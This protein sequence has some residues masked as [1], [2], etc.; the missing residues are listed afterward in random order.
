MDKYSVK[1]LSRAFH[2]LDSIYAYIAGTLLEPDTALLMLDTLEEAIFSL[3]KLPR[4]GTPR[5]RGAY[6]N[7]GYRQL[8]IENFTVVYRV[9]DIKKQV[10]IV[11]VRYSKSQ[12]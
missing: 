2:D 3:E 9:D 10:V 6:A 7:K 8:F 4:R 11:T 1:L 12:F 5:Q